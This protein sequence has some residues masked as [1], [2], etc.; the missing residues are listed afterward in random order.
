MQVACL[1]PLPLA[2]LVVM[3]PCCPLAAAGVITEILHDPGRGAPLARVRV[4][5]RWLLL[6]CMLFG[7]AMQGCC[8][9]EPGAGEEGGR[10]HG[11]WRGA[12]LGAAQAGRQRTDGM[13]SSTGGRR[14]GMGSA[15]CR[16]LAA[17]LMRGARTSQAQQHAVQQLW[18]PRVWRLQTPSG[19]AK[20][21]VVASPSQCSQ[22]VQPAGQQL[23]ACGSLP[24]LPWVGDEPAQRPHC[25]LTLLLL[26]CL[27]LPCPGE[28]PPHGALRH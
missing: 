11:V 20:A 23:A 7:W 4:C 16:W 10:Q 2:A 27:T 26:N 6:G 19:A 25:K 13:T 12:A 17:G 15:C 24:R 21:S 9:L 5:F 22:P 14:S 3:S 28:L 8:A 18:L 1:L